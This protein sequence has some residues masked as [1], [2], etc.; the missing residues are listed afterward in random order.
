[1]Q[2]AHTSQLDLIWKLPVSHV[3]AGRLQLIVATIAFG[4]GINKPDVRFVI[5]HSLSKS[6]ENYYQESGAPLP[7]FTPTTF[8]LTRRTSQHASA[9]AHIV[10]SLEC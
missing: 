4:M 2:L 7:C 3:P 10:Y 5:H 6:L 9:H 1:M 8:P